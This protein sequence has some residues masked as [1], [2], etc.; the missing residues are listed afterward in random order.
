MVIPFLLA[1][2][3]IFQSPAI[4]SGEVSPLSTSIAS[5]ACASMGAT[6]DLKLPTISTTDMTVPA[7]L[8]SDLGG[9]A[10]PGFDFYYNQSAF[11]LNN[12]GFDISCTDHLGAQSTVDA[13]ACRNSSFECGTFLFD[14]GCGTHLMQERFSRFMS[15]IQRS[16]LVVSGFDRSTQRASDTGAAS[17]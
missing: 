10:S 16:S 1:L 3:S 14:P 13:F 12:A 17:M 5:Y 8:T 15:S 7:T 9:A 6:L 11:S 4:T 2:L